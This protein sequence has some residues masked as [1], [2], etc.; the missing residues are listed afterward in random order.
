MGSIWQPAREHAPSRRSVG[1]HVGWRSVPEVGRPSISLPRVHQL[2]ISPM[3][4]NALSLMPYNHASVRP[5]RWDLVVKF[6]AVPGAAGSSLALHASV[7][8]LRADT[9]I[10]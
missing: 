5:A 9:N 2:H 1:A 7:M 6:C 8:L 10:P 3:M 4:I